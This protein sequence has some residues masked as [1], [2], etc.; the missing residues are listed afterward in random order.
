MSFQMYI[1]YESVINRCDFWENSGL[2]VQSHPP[3][4]LSHTWLALKNSKVASDPFQ[5]HKLD[6][7]CTLHLINVSK[8]WLTFSVIKMH[9]LPSCILS[10][11][12][13]FSCMHTLPPV[14]VTFMHAQPT[15]I[16][17]YML[18]FTLCI[19]K[20]AVTRL[21]LTLHADLQ[22]QIGSQNIFT[23]DHH[24]IAEKSAKNATATYKR[25][26]SNK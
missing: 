22:Q 19:C 21:F 3:P 20:K 23:R 5:A 25:R 9:T 10:L 1:L 12:A 8:K 15:C 11:H 17:A 4:K 2:H 16:L 6:H 26:L 14:Y 13:Y 18:S 7:L 24:L